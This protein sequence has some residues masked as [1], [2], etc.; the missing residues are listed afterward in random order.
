MLRTQNILKAA[1]LF[2][3]FWLVHF[4][5]DSVFFVQAA[6]GTAL[7]ILFVTSPSRAIKLKELSDEKYP[8]VSVIVPMRNEEKNVVP[9]LSSIASLDYPNYEIIIA[10]DSSTD[11]T[12]ATVL[13]MQKKHAGKAAIAL[14]DVPVLPLGWTGKTW[15]LHNAVKLAKHDIWLVC[16]ADVRHKPQSLK[17][18]ISYFLEHKPDM[19]ARTPWPITYTPGEW[20]MIF[21]MFAIRFSSWFSNLF[22]KSSQ[23]FP[24]EQYVVMTRKFYEDT[25]GYRAVRDFV[26]E[27]MALENVAR[28][29][30]KKVTIMDDDL[31]EITVRMHEGMKATTDGIVRATDFRVIGFYPFLGISLIIAWAMGGLYEIFTGVVSGAL[32][33][34]TQGIINYSLFSAVFAWYLR[35]SKHNPL[36]GI[37]APILTTHILYLAFLAVIGKVLKKQI[38]WKGRAV[39]AMQS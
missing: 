16:D 25:G 1:F 29:L 17:H 33:M 37:F 32:P 2:T 19:M 31:K 24:P 39:L 18:S 20:P 4:L 27:V 28:R 15:A 3:A 11:G 23:V 21:S 14:F 7:F 10:N 8:P 13:E 36:I 22:L 35:H 9:C 26:P 34:L 5:V 38:T 6:V 30:G 12:R